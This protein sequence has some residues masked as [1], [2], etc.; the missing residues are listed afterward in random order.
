MFK[1]FVYRPLGMKLCSSVYIGLG[2]NLS[3]PP[4]QLRTALKALSVLPQ[5]RLQK[6]SQFYRTQ[7]LGR[8]WQPGYL[9]AVAQLKTSLQ[10]LNLL[11][12]LQAIELRQ[13]RI[14]SGN[15]WGPRTLDLDI[16][17][18]GDRQIE[19]PRL[20]VPHYDLARRDFV[21][22]PLLEIAP[23]GMQ[24]PGLGSLSEL[25][26]CFNDGRESVRLQLLDP[27]IKYHGN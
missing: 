3:N 9:N 10:P 2:S 15:R 22:L 4:N 5:T 27:K 6:V 25:S 26:H 7:P 14:R 17:L 21:I 11:D 19:H 8:A 16:L 20:R 23:P 12:R 18:F 1:L 13:G 24:I